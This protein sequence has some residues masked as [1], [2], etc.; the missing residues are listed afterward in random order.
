MRQSTTQQSGAALIM[1]LLLIAI[2]AAISTTIMFSQQVDVE[3]AILQTTANQA[4][5]DMDYANLWWQQQWQQ[6]SVLRDK[7]QQLPKWPQQLAPTTLANG[8]VVSAT[9]TPATAR[10]NINNLAQPVSQ[11][12][13]IFTGLIQAVDQNIDAATA[14]QL[15]LNTQQ[16][17][18]PQTTGVQTNNPYATMTP[19]YQAAHQQMTSASELRLVQGIT[20]NLFQRLRPYII[21]LPS[22]DIPI[23]VN[24]AAEPVLLAMLGQNSGAAEE[25]I[26]YRNSRNGFLNSSVFLGLPSV[27]AYAQS[28]ASVAS[29]FSKLFSTTAPTYF[30]V[31][32]VVKHAKMQFQRTSVL[33]YSPQTKQFTVLQQGQSL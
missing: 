20:A 16:W 21:A 14:Q 27:K 15:A 33:Q 8:D 13:T 10:F 19:A 32:A 4:H 1:A 26:A 18:T 29:N 28:V 2:V 24:S 7:Q 3:R 5:L 6:L 23:D 25:V 11:Y 31:H 12:L 22:T 9:V 30:L 17:L